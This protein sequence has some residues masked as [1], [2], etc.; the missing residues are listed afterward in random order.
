MKKRSRKNVRKAEPIDWAELLFQGMVF[1]RGILSDDPKVQK[2]CGD[3]LNEYSGK[4]KGTSGF[5]R[6]RHQLVR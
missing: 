1:A 6:P 4:P 2:A 5:V 3:I